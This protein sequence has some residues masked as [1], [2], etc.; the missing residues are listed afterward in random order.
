MH[1]PD[2][3]R[4]QLN[5]RLARL[6]IPIRVSNI[7]VHHYGHL[8]RTAPTRTTDWIMD[9]IPMAPKMESR[10]PDARVLL[11]YVSYPVTTEG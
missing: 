3:V 10:Y 4:D 8:C 1:M 6:E 2:M 9:N 7:P 11:A 5:E